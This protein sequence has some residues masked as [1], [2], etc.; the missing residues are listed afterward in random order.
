MTEIQRRGSEVVLPGSFLGER[1]GGHKS[2]TFTD[3]SRISQWE[4]LYKDR[5]LVLV[6]LH[7]I[8]S[9]SLLE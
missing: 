9:E 5:S 3:Y 7:L 4:S 2:I 1:K 8:N 6:S